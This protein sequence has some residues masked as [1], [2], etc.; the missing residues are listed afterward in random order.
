MC[1]WC[2]REAVALDLGDDSVLRDL[3][4]L[5]FYYFFLFSCLGCCCCWEVLRALRF[6]GTRAAVVFVCFAITF[7]FDEGLHGVSVKVSNGFQE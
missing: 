6:G 5:L 4:C 7:C 2:L 1:V 3:K